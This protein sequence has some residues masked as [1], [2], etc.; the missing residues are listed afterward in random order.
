MVY[1]AVLPFGWWRL[2][3]DEGGIQLSSEFVVL[4]VVRVALLQICSA[5]IRTFQAGIGSSKQ[6]R[7]G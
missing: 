6:V 3:V 4:D 2:D 7:R 1:C 5:F